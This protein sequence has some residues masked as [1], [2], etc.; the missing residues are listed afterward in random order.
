MF[1]V[2]EG[3]EFVMNPRESGLSEGER[4]SSRVI[5]RL[6]RMGRKYGLGVCIASQRVAH[7]NTTAIS[8]CHTTSLELYHASTTVMQ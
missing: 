5:E 6:T 4:T 2:D 7:L 3:H 8:N 1:V